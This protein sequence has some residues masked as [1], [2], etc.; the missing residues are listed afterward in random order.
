MNNKKSLEKQAIHQPFCLKT[1]EK[2]DE[3][4]KIT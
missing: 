2:V 1:A 4:Q 3:H